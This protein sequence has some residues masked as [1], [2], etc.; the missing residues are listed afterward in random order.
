MSSGYAALIAAIYMGRSLKAPADQESGMFHDIKEP[1]NVPIVM[2]GTALLWFGWFGVSEA[3]HFRGRSSHKATRVPSFV[4]LL[5]FVLVSAPAGVPCC[6][7][8]NAGSAGGAGYISGQAFINTQA[9]AAA[10]MLTFMLM[11]R[12]QYTL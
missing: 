4:R 8:F 12:P 6:L 2:L 7:Q 3:V 5:S 1:A 9:A 11:V 10:S